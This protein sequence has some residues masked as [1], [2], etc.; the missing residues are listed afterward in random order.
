MFNF[1]QHK[2]LNLGRVQFSVWGKF[3]ANLSGADC[4]GFVLNRLA[5][6]YGSRGQEGRNDSNNRGR[7]CQKPIASRLQ[8]RD[9]LLY[10]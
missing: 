2:L 1:S 8:N 9:A 5:L 7:E 10:T 3:R 4:G 6:C